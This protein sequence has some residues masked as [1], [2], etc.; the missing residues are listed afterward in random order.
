V[1][2][3]VIMTDEMLVSVSKFLRRAFVGKLEEDE[4]VNCVSV[5]ENE[6][7]K[8]RIDAAR[9]HRSIRG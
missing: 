1:G 8:R 6:I 4:L 9:K 5:I 7:M 2:E 3:E